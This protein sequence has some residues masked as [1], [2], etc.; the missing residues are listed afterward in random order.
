M[1]TTTAFHFLLASSSLRVILLYYIYTKLN[2]L[3]WFVGRTW[4]KS[5]FEEENV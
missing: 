4:E 5:H 2:A 1:I 3:S